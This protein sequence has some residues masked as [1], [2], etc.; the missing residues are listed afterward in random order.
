MIS[1]EAKKLAEERAAR[2]QAAVELKEPDRV[3]FTGVGGDVI[4][5]YAGISAYEY[6]FDFEKNRQAAIK[7]FTDFPSDSAPR[8]GITGIGCRVM[9]VAFADFPDLADSFGSINGPMNDILKMNFARFPGRELGEESSPQ[10]IGCC[11]MTPDE[12]DQLIAD[13]VRFNFEKIVPR[14]AGNLK[15]LGSPTALATMAR[16][17]MEKARQN[18]EMAKTIQALK[19]LGYSFGARGSCL[20]PLDYIGDQLRD[21]PNLILDLRR[22]PDKVK[23]AAEALTEPLLRIALRSKEVGA[24]EVFIPLHLNEYLS[25]KQYNEFYWPTLKE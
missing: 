21:I 17:G 19:Q 7:W 6:E 9:P 25:P 10:F 23:A 13:P 16:L 8:A 15:D 14:I 4:P 1:P 2:M 24:K 18:V 20:A 11:N 22:Y 5:A 3:P 12:Y